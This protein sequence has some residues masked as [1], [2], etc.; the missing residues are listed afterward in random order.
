MHLPIIF[1]CCTWAVV[2]ESTSAL[3]VSTQKITSKL[4]TATKRHTK[5]ATILELLPTH[6]NHSPFFR[7]HFTGSSKYFGLFPEY[8]LNIRG[9]STSLRITKVIE[10]FLD[11]VAAS[12][13]KSWAVLILSILIETLAST[14]SKRARDTSNALLFFS[15]VCMNLIR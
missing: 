1:A 14:I 8:V 3:A 13:S 10:G 5:T 7:D 9:G 6:R 15:S 2:L 12:R 4:S 11:D